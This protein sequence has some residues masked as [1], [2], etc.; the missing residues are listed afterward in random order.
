MQIVQYAHNEP[1]QVAMNGVPPRHRR[2]RLPKYASREEK[3]AAYTTRKRLRRRQKAFE[4]R[5]EEA[6]LFYLSLS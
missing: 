3:V 5:A 6:R 4:R 1:S 2:G